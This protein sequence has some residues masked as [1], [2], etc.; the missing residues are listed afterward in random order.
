M[1]RLAT[2]WQDIGP[3]RVI[4]RP[5]LVTTMAG[6]VTTMAAAPT[7]GV[8]TG[9]MIEDMIVDVSMSGASTK[10]M[11]GTSTRADGGGRPLPTLVWNTIEFAVITGIYGPYQWLEVDYKLGEFLAFCPQVILGRYLVITA[12]DS[13]SFVLSETNRANGWTNSAGIAYGPRIR[14]A[15]EL[16]QDD[17][18]RECYGFDEWYVFDLPPKSLGVLRGDRW[19]G[20]SRRRSQQ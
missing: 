5:L 11:N 8:A 10:S 12:V 3:H 15:A 9:T 16:P 7:G 18:G 17:Y 2:G 14:L 6:A 13:G 4:T 1:R 19:N 20:D